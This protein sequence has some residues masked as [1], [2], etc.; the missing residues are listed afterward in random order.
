MQCSSLRAIMTGITI[1]I[2][3]MGI[4]MKENDIENENSRQSTDDVKVKPWK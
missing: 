1:I 2:I 4:R 3:E